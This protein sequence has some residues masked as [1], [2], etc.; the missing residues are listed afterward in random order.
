MM[1]RNGEDLADELPMM[2][3]NQTVQ[4]KKSVYSVNA[5]LGE[6]LCMSKQRNGKGGGV[7]LICPRAYA[8][9]AR[10]I[11]ADHHEH[12]FDRFIHTGQTTE[13]ARPH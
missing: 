9:L 1:P 6:T 8:P 13:Y 5:L 10:P 7:Y 3:P 12:K 4:S 11:C 2:L